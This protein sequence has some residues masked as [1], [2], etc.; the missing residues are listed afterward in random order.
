MRRNS[1]T[2]GKRTLKHKRRKSHKRRT[3]VKKRKRRRSRH[4]GGYSGTGNMI[5]TP[6][7]FSPTNAYPPNGAVLV[8]SPGITKVATRG[9]EQQYYYAKNNRV[10]KAPESTNPQKQSGGRKRRRTKKRK[11]KH[12]KRKKRKTR[13]RKKSRKR[14][15]RRRYRGG[16]LSDVIEAIPGGTDLRDVFYKSGNLAGSLYSQYNGYGPTNEPPMTNYTAGQPI[17]KSISLTSG[18]IPMHQYIQDGSL[19]A[20]KFKAGYN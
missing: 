15:R 7:T 19:E 14:R 18:D 5:L 10:M 16:G 4:R 8:P 2:G 1:L 6:A 11:R 20:S 13:K 17:N 9:S 3:R 12:K